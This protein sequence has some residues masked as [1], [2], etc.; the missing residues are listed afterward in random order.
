M[1]IVVSSWPGAGGT[2]VSIML[3]DL[4]GYK[5]LSI[6]SIL[7]YLTTAMY[8]S[9]DYSL[10]VNFEREFGNYWDDILHQYIEWKLA[11][12][13][14]IVVDGRVTGFFVENEKKI[15]EIMVIADMTTRINR[16]SKSQ[17]YLSEQD[18]VT[19]LRWLN[20]LHIDIFNL[21]Q[22]ELNYDLI[23]D[24]STMSLGDELFV[25]LDFLLYDNHISKKQY[26]ELSQKI[27]TIKE[28]TK[29]SKVSNIEKKLLLSNQFIPVSQILQEWN[30]RFPSVIEKMPNELKIIIKAHH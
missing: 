6:S 20:K 28:E 14:N 25:I 17:F 22:I 21:R 9:S 23:I 15:F 8:K 29:I 7:D 4:L 10:R 16:Y 18:N 24:N 30:K 12:E 19:R 5:F 3:T 26:K 2:S 27:A 1:N 11:N 13:D